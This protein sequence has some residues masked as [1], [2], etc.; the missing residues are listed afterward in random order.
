M[1][2][3]NSELNDIINAHRQQLTSQLRANAGR[4]SRE[5]KLRS[6]NRIDRNSGSI[7][8]IGISFEKHGIYVEKGVGRGRGINSGRTNPMPWFN[9]VM[10]AR[11]PILADELAMNAAD[12]LQKA[13]IK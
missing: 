5:Y 7:F 3:I 8:A 11:I 9:P 10:E 2:K 12:L 6:N 1:K 13:L 4:S